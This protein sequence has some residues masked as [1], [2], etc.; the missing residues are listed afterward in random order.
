MWTA[1]LTLPVVL[2]PGAI[3]DLRPANPSP[4]GIQWWLNKLWLTGKYQWGAACLEATERQETIGW[5]LRPVP[6]AK[7]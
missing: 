1:S 3:P 6:I 5:L 7:S 2:I 4:I